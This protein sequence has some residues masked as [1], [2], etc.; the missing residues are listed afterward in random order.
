[1]STDDFASMFEQ[2]S[3]NA[4]ATPR[5]E[6]GS[7]VE[8]T[9]IELS[10]GL[11]IVDIGGAAD[12]TLDLAEFEDRPVRVGDPIRATVK[13][14]SPDGPVLTLSLGRGGTSVGTDALLLASEA[15]TPVSGTV[16]AEVKGGL[17][18]DVS[19]V[20]AFCPVSQIDLGYVADPA[21]FVGQTLDFLVLEVK[22]GGSNV[23]LSRRKLLERQQ[24]DAQ[25]QLA[26]TL[27]VG[28]TVTGTVKSTVRHGALIDL[29]GVDGFVHIS[30]LSRTRVDKPEDVVTI[31]EQVQAKIS[32]IEQGERGL[33]V[34]LS[35]KA[36][37]APKHNAPAVDEILDGQVSRHVGGGLLVSTEKGEGFVPTRELSLP[38]GADPRRAYPVG[39]SLRV[40]LVAHDAAT[41]RLRFS[42]G[43][44]ADVE[45]RRNYRDFGQAGS[46]SGSLGSLGD[47]MRQ[48]LGDL[49]APTPQAA[50]SSGQPAAEHEETKEP[51]RPTKKEHVGVT[52]RRR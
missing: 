26:R 1:M 38:P 10:G 36:L 17:T 32:S 33:N 24:K 18:V 20:R 16:S 22:E 19:G 39:Q 6:A 49:D 34:R 5:L 15:E 31:G 50:G 46:A 41:G 21:Q 3:A 40:V 11:V 8:G 12:A 52:R 25:E 44:V 37:E 42:V 4:R 48:K 2:S 35:L 23:I 43:K 45:E 51:E 13:N 27:E 28:S 9:V 7:Q 47:V 29:G 14:P 30:E